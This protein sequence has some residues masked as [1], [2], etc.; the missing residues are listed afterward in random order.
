MRIHDP[1]IYIKILHTDDETFDEPLG[2][3]RPFIAK[4]RA[5]M[6]SALLPFE[7]LSITNEAL[8]CTEYLKV[9]PQMPPPPR[10]HKPNAS[11]I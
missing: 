1:A 6:R 5:V 11:T 10:L 4:E 8:I 9:L 3:V 7:R 2:L